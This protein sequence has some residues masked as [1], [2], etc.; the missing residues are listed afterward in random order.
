MTLRPHEP[1]A[2]IACRRLFTP[3]TVLDDVLITFEKDGSIGVMGEFASH[4]MPPNV[5][6][7]RR[8]DVK[9][10]PG[11][12]D[13]HIHGGGGADFRELDEASLLRISE[14]AARGG[15][16]SIIATLTLPRDEAGFE[17]LSDFVRLLRTTDP[18]GARVLGIFLEGPFINPRKHGAFGPDY[19]WPV[20][21]ARA[22]RLLS[23]CGD[24]LLKITVA[25][26]IDGGTRL[27]E[28]F[29][30]NPNTHVEV[31]LGHS[32][33]DYDTARR[34]FRMERVRQVTHAFNAMDSFH[35]RAPGLI[36]AAL[37]DD[38][39]LCEMIPD[40]FHLVGPTI[41][42]L[43][44]MKGRDRL[45]IVTDGAAATGTKPGTRIMGLSGWTEVRD[46]AVRLPD[47]TLAGS[48]LL[49]ASAVRSAC[50]LGHVPFQDALRMATVTP[51][52][53]VH[54]EDRVASIEPRKRADFCVLDGHGEVLATIRDG[55]AVYV[56]SA[57]R[58]S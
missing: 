38:R 1:L 52:L 49:M 11:L 32:V 14:N 16:S 50:E 55:R 25:P 26:E 8:P 43:Y 12:I 33:V 53:S 34:L 24:L 58:E 42:L 5:F 21:L 36:G 47:G 37:L 10:V 35:H 45:M 51:A 46:G 13:V 15:A 31:S 9:V 54:W 39:V 48:N 4:Q 20:D 23:L 18:P 29:H 44:R 30:E 7:A 28:L 6:D 40:G 56:A 3:D 22:E 41:E 2:G 27:I 57:A 17:R 19:I